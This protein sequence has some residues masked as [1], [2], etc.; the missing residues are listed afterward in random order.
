MK[1]LS[2]ADLR[3]RIT[4]S[5]SVETDN[6]R[7]GSATAWTPIAKPWAEVL[8]L[9]GRESVMNKV[10]QGVSVYRIRIRYRADIEPKQQIRFGSATLNIK[11]VSDPFGTRR[12][13]V[14][15][16]DTESTLG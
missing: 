13:L 4:I 5:A 8:G 12:E 15:M 14:I 11:S 9:D 3:H 10:L 2:A 7:G 1:P 6:G 16:A